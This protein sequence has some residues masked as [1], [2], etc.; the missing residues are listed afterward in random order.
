MGAFGRMILAV[1]MVLTMG[2]VLVG[3]GGNDEQVIKDGLSSNLEQFK[4]PKSAQWQE[5]IS[6]QGSQ[7]E[8]VGI[9][10]QELVVAWVDGFEFSIDSV[11]VTDDTAVVEITITCKQLNAAMQSATSALLAD[12]SLAELSTDEIEKKTADT[13]MSE[14]RALQP[15][16]TSITVECV[17]NGNEWTERAGAVAAYT[18]AFVG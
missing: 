11:T 8:S 3:C 1:L 17:K 12:E 13:I 4:D 9:D 14:L 15:A 6:V 16:T 18:S 7:L 5:I 2:T 10:P